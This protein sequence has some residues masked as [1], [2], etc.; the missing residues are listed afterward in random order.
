M[1]A[2]V[3]G[4]GSTIMFLGFTNINEFSNMLGLFEND[5]NEVFLEDFVVEHIRFFPS[6]NNA[7]I[8]IRN[9]GAAEITVDSIAVVKI[10]TQELVLNN[11]TISQKIMIGDVADIE[12]TFTL[13][14]GTKQFDDASYKSSEYRISVST[15]R[16]N[17]F[18]MIAKPFNT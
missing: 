12:Q 10:D 17:S 4:A 8:T 15:T 6:G 5:R 7:T 1:L 3:V 2:I 14:Q 11:N 16:A 13:T 18:E 9:T